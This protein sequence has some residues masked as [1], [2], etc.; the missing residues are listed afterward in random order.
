MRPGPPREIVC[1]VAALPCTAGAIDQLA[2]LQLAARRTDAEVR[3]RNLS[4]ELRELLDFAGLGDVLRVEAS[5]QSEEGEQR[6]GV[7]E[8]GQLGDPPS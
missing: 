1:D 2:R 3:L 6:V 4:H 5:R 8:E 7:E